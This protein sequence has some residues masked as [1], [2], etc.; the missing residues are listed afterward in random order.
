[1][2]R[3]V[4][5][6]VLVLCLSV[7]ACGGGGGD[8]SAAD[9][10]DTPTEDTSTTETDCAK[11]PIAERAAAV[12]IVGID[13]DKSADR[14][15][16]AEVTSIGVGGVELRQPNVDDEAQVR[17]LIEG[18]RSQSRR[19][20]LLSVDEEGG[21]V[22]RLRAILGS[23]STARTLGAQPLEAITAEALRRGRLMKDLGIDIVL[24]PV[25]D[26]DGGPAN[27][28]I[29]DRSFSGDQTQ[30]GDRA[31]AFASGLAQAGLLATVKHFPGSGG[32][33]DDSHA[34]AVKSPYTADQV[35]AAARAFLPSIEAGATAVMMSHVT[36]ES[37]GPLPASVEPAAYELL[38]SLGFD[39]VAMTDALGMG[40]IVERWTIPQAAVV[41]INA[42]ADMVLVNQGVEAV[43]M[44][45]AIVAAVADGSLPETRLDEAV[46]RVLRWRGDDPATM[47]CA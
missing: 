46:G 18:L 11:A 7:A 24:G 21:R 19:K 34:G 40:A 23:T 37:L 33:S 12:L 13:G 9:N 6:L 47:V 16:A 39:G 30:A 1:M 25:A 28:A 26:A 15:L 8:D 17:A 4:L 31:A 45:D 38:R 22:S 42:G 3:L 35:E 36:Y 43:G 44:R 10:R 14:S 41:A 32:V 5:A 2:R 27:G 29:G 20:L